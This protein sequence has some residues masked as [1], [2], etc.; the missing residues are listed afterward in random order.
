MCSRFY[1]DGL[2]KIKHLCGNASAGSIAATKCPG[3]SQITKSFYTRPV[4]NITKQNKKQNKQTNKSSLNHIQT[5][6]KNRVSVQSQHR[7][8]SGKAFKIPPSPEEKD[9]ASLQ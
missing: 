8:G 4:G 5:P 2:W 9:A 7:S 3:G 1:L 6:L